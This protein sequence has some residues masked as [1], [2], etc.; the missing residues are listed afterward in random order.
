MAIETH[1]TDLFIGEDWNKPFEFTP[2]AS[3]AGDELQFRLYDPYPVVLITR[4]IAAGE[5]VVSNEATGVG[6]LKVPRSQTRTLAE[7][8]YRWEFGRVNSG[9][10][11][12]F[13]YGLIDLRRR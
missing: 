8:A 12:V 5:I 1:I 2:P 10:W 6:T 4:N 3:V 9:A 13:G 11:K 7:K